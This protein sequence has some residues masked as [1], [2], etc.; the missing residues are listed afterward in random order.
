MD[1]VDLIA[2]K[3]FENFLLCNNNRG[4]VDTIIK[5]WTSS[6][7]EKINGW[8]KNEEWTRQRLKE[9]WLYIKAREPTKM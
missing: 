5:E 3:L 6:K 7:R 1:S 9:N 4:E 2:K 8:E